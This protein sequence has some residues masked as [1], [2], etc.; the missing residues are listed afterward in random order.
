MNPPAKG[1]ML[2]SAL[3]EKIKSQEPDLAEA[4]KRLAGQLVSLVLNQS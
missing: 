1:E 2:I 3:I 4:E